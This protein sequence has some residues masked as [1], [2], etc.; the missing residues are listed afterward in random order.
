MPAQPRT[1]RSHPRYAAKGS[2][3]G[4]EMPGLRGSKKGQHL[5]GKVEDISDGGFCIIAE[6]TPGKSSL[7]QGRLRLAK[8]PC[9]IPTLVQVRWAKRAASGRQYMIGVQYVL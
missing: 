4:R 9:Q 7:L 6:K 5:R 1:K 3:E 2:F 8:L